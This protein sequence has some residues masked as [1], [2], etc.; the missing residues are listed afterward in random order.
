[1]NQRHGGYGQQK[2]LPESG[3]HEPA[4]FVQRGVPDHRMVGLRIA[5]RTAETSRLRSG[6]QPK[7]SG[8]R[9]H[10]DRCGKQRRIIESEQK[11]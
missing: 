7:N 11:A 1:M 4:H 2:R 3:G 10:V 6:R 8:T 5:D 9:R